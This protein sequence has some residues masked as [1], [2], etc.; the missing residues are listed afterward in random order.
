MSVDTDVDVVESQDL[1]EQ[2]RRANEFAAT[3]LV[4][5]EEME[6]FRM[7]VSPLYSRVKVLGFSARMRVHPGIVAGQIRHAERNYKL[8]HDMLV[9]IRH[10]V[11]S[12]SL[13]DGWGASVTTTA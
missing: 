5:R 7:R 9:K 12:S 10:I 4:P 2:E 6:D 13:T 8:F 3:A 11:A 1:P